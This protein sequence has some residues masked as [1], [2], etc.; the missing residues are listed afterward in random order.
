M[1]DDNLLGK[2]DVD[3]SADGTDGQKGKADETREQ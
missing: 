3:S 2:E 1:L